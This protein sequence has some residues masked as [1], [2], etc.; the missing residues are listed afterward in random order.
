MPKA[1]YDVQRLHKT[2]QFLGDWLPEDGLENYEQR[3][4]SKLQ[5]YFQEHYKKY[6]SKNPTFF[7][8]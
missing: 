4:E 3:L 2:L 1:P 8:R 6:I 5:T 7:K